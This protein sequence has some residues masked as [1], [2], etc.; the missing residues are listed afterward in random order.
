MMHSAM[1]ALK[2]KEEAAEALKQYAHKIALMGVLVSARDKA[3][4]EATNKLNEKHSPA[5]TALSGEL[6]ALKDQL[7]SWSNE[8]R[9]LLFC[10][11][12]SLELEYGFLKFRKGQR[13]LVCLAR[14]TWE[15]TLDALM[16]FPVT[17]QWQEY[18]R[19]TPEVDK[20]KLLDATKPGGKL[21]EEKLRE[22]GCRVVRE[23]SFSIETKP[24]M[25]A[26]DCDVMP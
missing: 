25:I 4:L 13:K 9:A 5:I 8:S 7:E 26:R 23:E 19:R 2:T 24:E 12:Q 14:W 18:I 17:S 15:K 6:S 11:D 3:V 16:K 10:D 21:P 22:I 20:R 1:E